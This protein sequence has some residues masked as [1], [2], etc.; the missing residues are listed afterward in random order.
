MRG[1]CGPRFRSGRCPDARLRCRTSQSAPRRVLS[2]DE[3]AAPPRIIWR[4]CRA[5]TRQLH[6]QALRR[7]VSDG[8]D[9]GS[10]PAEDSEGH[11]GRWRCLRWIL[12]RHCCCPCR[13]CRCSI[14][15]QPQSRLLQCRLFQ[16][17]HLRL[18]QPLLRPRRRPPVRG[19]NRSKRRQAT[20]TWPSRKWSFA[21]FNSV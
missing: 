7:A 19:R 10:G 2:A 3:M 20:R 11:P 1:P 14:R 8:W 4:S 9:P 15:C 6:F 13:L 17:W 12:N 5:R 18:R 16:R 21:C